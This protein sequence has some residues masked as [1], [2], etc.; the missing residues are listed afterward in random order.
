M[1]PSFAPALPSGLTSNSCS[2]SAWPAV[3]SDAALSCIE[4]MH[5]SWISSSPK[6]CFSIPLV[7]PSRGRNRCAKR[8]NSTTCTSGRVAAALLG[9]QPLPVAPQLALRAR[10]RAVADM[11]AGGCQRHI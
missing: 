5:E 2:T 10:C 6:A 8:Y 3:S 4:S 9:A 11:G 1:Q 7:V